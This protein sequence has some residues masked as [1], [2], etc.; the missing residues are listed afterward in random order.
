MIVPF[1]AGGPADLYARYLAARMQDSLGQPFVVENRPGR[2]A[3]P[4]SMS[5]AEFERYLQG[6]IAKWAKVVKIAGAR[7]DR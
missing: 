3:V 7:S 2:A 6:D 4:M 5:P 1:A